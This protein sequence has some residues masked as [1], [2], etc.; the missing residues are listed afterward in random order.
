M[1]EKKEIEEEGDKE[2]HDDESSGYECDHVRFAQEEN[3]EEKE[4]EEKEAE[5]GE[6]KEEEEENEEENEEEKEEEEEAEE[7]STTRQFGIQ[8]F[9]MDKKYFFTTKTQH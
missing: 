9:T 2:K 1:K 6:E 5:N 4:E 8:N 7:T 3:E